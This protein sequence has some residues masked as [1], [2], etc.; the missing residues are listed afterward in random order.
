MESI[1]NPREVKFND[2]ASSS[3]FNKMNKEIST[4]FT[5]LFQNLATNS[6]KLNDIIETLQ[7]NNQQLAN[8]ISYL[9]TQ[10]NNMNVDKEYIDFYRDDMLSYGS[11]VNEDDKECP[12]CGKAVSDVKFQKIQGD[13]DE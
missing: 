8:R 2:I 7:V 13:E 5:N 4:D 3:D 1:F 12:N 6:N 10:I 11:E 9:E